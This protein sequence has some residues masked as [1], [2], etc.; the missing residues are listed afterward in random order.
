MAIPQLVAHRG[1]P[2]H[3]PENTLIG[4]EA[5]IRA[6]ARLVE[7]DVQLSADEVPVLLHDKS[8]QRVCGFKGTV[9]HLS[10]DQLRA[11]H[12]SEFERFGYRFAQ[13]HIPSLA[14][15]CQLLRAWPGVTAFVELKQSSIDH[16][17]ETVVLNRVL[18]ELEPVA[19]QVVLI[20]FSLD[21]LLTARKR[22]VALLGA[23]LESWRQRKHAIIRE[24]GPQYIICNVQLLPRWGHLRANNAK[25]VV[26]EITSARRALNLAARGVDFV[27][28]FAVGEMFEQLELLQAQPLWSTTK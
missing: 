13:L 12:P 23:V 2:E 19:S 17:G 9:H 10:Y 14:E 6:G 5:A 16:F 22:G 7:I 24:I 26:Y 4:V 20:S 25:L 28:T 27:E 15:F 3:F 21:I 8:L 11:L 18:R 1:Y